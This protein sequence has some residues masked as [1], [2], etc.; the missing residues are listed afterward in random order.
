MSADY[1]HVIPRKVATLKFRRVEENMKTI[2]ITLPDNY[3]EAEIRE[4]LARLPVKKLEPGQVAYC[5]WCSNLDNWKHE[6]RFTKERWA[7]VEQACRE[8]YVE[9]DKI[10][11][12]LATRVCLSLYETEFNDGFRNAWDKLSRLI[13]EALK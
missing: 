13:R 9:T 1:K 2:E 11:A 12:A 3:T 5:S 4:H 10:E 7:A 6:T 8:G